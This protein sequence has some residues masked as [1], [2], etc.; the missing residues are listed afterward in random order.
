MVALEQGTH[1]WTYPDFAHDHD[2]LRY[3][4]RYAMMV[5]LAR[6]TWTWR[7]TPDKP[8]LPMR[9]YGSFNPGE[10]LGGAAIHWSAQLWRFLQ[11]D[12]RHRSHIVE[13]YGASK[14]PEGSTIQDWPV[15]YDDLESYYDAFEW[16]IG[17]SGIAGNIRGEIQPGGNP[18]E[19]PRSRGYPNPPLATNRF[20]DMFGSACTELGLHPFP[21]PAGITSRAFTDPYG[22]LRSGL[23]LLRLLHPLRLRGRR[24]G[25]PAEHPPSG[26]ARD[27][28][29]RRPARLQGAPDRDRGRRPRDRR[30]LRRR[31]GP[32][33]LPARRRRRRL[34]LHAREQPAAPAL[35]LAASTRSGIGND[36]GRV[37]RNYTYQIYPQTV[38]GLWEG[39]KLNMYMGNTCTMNIVYDYNADVFDHSDLDFI[40]GMQ[41]FSEPGE[42]EPVNSVTDLKTK[43]GKT[44]GAEWKS[45]LGRNWD[46]YAGINTEGES[47]PYEDQ[48]LDLDPNYTDR[49]GNPLLRLT[50]SWHENEKRMWRYMYARSLEIMN[51]MNP[52]RL[53]AT[54]PE[55]PDYNIAK[56][57]STHPTGGCIMGS[58]PGDSVTNSYGQVW[59]TPNV[60]VTGA[61]LFPQNPGANPTGTVAALAY[62]T[63]DAIAARYWDSP[64]ELL[65]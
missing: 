22:N 58:S 20:A 37:G 15:G 34:G 12:F 52:S 43:S 9:Q 6:E 4:V 28:P 45:E 1:R 64:N 11:Y 51:A 21:Q 39:Q 25:E 33:A 16:D 46:S 8:A 61:A 29:L 60:F 26:R 40:G 54:T 14:L 55:I 23:P 65:D 30:H 24:E 36:R 18:F 13:R 44:W 17:A 10:G 3:S 47:I 50:F 62:R 5:D 49:F 27:R 32:G 63:A 59:D 42:R 41:L 53:V 7:P 35:T 2:S 48:F 38:V 57:Q 19:E 31:Q 56:Y